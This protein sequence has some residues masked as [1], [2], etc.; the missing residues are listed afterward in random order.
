VCIFVRKD[1]CFNKTDISHSCKEQDF[2]ICA[3][4]LETKTA[5][6]I[7]LSLY[8]APSGDLIQ[9]LKRLDV[10][11]KYLYNPKSYFIICGSINIDYLDENKSN[12]GKRKKEKERDELIR[13]TQVQQLILSL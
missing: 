3:I 9:F 6:L 13:M 2:E 12:Q 7:I 11:L 8:R 1:Q 4:R 10:T 5:N